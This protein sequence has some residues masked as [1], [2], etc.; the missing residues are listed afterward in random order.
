MTRDITA[1]WAQEQISE[2]NRKNWVTVKHGFRWTLW[3]T[4]LSGSAEVFLHQHRCKQY[5]W[6]TSDLIQV[7][8]YVRCINSF[9][10][11]PEQM[12]LWWIRPSWAYW[13]SSCV[14]I[15]ATECRTSSSTPLPPAAITAIPLKPQQSDPSCISDSTLTFWL[16]LSTCRDPA[17]ASSLLAAL[18]FNG[19]VNKSDIQQLLCRES[20]MLQGLRQ[21][22]SFS[23]AQQ[24][25]SAPSHSNLHIL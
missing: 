10:S 6:E 14:C 23:V 8:D 2:L 22:Q 17:L 12:Y 16:D 20:E 25:Y 1:S 5:S 19:R 21:V 18:P 4:T 11:L 13:H 7:R 24:L 3:N 9:S 15:H